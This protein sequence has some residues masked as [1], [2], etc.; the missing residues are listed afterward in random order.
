MERRLTAEGLDRFHNGVEM[1]RRRAAAAADDADA[2]FLDEL[3]ERGGHR[4]RLERIDRV[5]RARV[6]GES[7][8]RDDGERTARDIGQETHRLAH[9]L[10]PRRAIEADDV[11][12]ERFERGERGGHVGA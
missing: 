11:D 8:V 10:R 1:L 9:V 5:A 12:G 2:V 3:L 4:R 6:E 7:S